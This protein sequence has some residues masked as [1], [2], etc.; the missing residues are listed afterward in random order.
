LCFPPSFFRTFLLVEF[1]AHYVFFS[2]FFWAKLLV[3]VCRWLSLP[4]AFSSRMVR[5]PSE[6]LRYFQYSL[7]Q[8]THPTLIPDDSTFFLPSFMGEIAERFRKLPFS[9]SPPFREFLLCSEF[10]EM[11]TFG[12]FSVSPTLG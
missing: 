12:S 11:M 2:T 6:F 4:P 9:F 8:A 10:A 5:L 3:G 7:T 1:A